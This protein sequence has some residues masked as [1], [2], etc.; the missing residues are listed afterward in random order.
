[1]VYNSVY[2]ILAEPK[3]V[4]IQGSKV[5]E[6]TR[7]NSVRVQDGF[8]KHCTGKFNNMISDLSKQSHALCLACNKCL[9]QQLG[10]AEVKRK[11][12]GQ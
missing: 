5:C 10:D 4:F 9:C 6:L 3:F 11:T 2:H 7:E 12:V 8:G 1:M